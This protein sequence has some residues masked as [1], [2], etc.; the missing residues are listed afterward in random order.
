MHFAMKITDRQRKPGICEPH[1]PGIKRPL[2]IQIVQSVQM[3]GDQHFGVRLA[4][5]STESGRPLRQ[6]SLR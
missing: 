4:R 3:T 1:L 5:Q 6:D 2:H